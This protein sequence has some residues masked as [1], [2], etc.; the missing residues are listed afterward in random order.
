MHNLTEAAGLHII[1]R[2]GANTKGECGVDSC[3]SFAQCLKRTLA[4]EDMSA[5]EAARLVG[6]KSR[7][8][9]FRILQ[10]STSCDINEHFLADLRAALGETWPES[11]YRALEEAL[12]ADRLG[13]DR[14]RC[15]I[16]FGKMLKGVAEEHA[17]ITVQT[18]TLEGEVSEMTLAEL[19]TQVAKCPKAEIVLTS[20]CDASFLRQLED[21]CGAAGENGT[22]TIRHYVDT[23]EDVVVGNILGILPLLSKTWY[24]ARL[25]GKGSCPAPMMQLYRLHAM[26]INCWD[27]QG[28]VVGYHMTRIDDRTFIRRI[29]ESGCYMINTLDRWRFHLELLKPPQNLTG[30]PQDFVAYTRNYA[31]L[32]EKCT[33]LSIKPD[34]HFNCIPPRILY[35]SIKDG[36]A[37]AGMAEGEELSQLMEE[38]WQIHEMRF[39]NLMRKR[40]PTHLVY[41]LPAMERFMRTGVLTDHFFIQRAYTVAER[42]EIMLQLRKAMQERPWFNVHFLKCGFEPKNEISYYSDRGV[43]IMDACTSYALGDDHSEALITLPAFSWAFHD[44]FTNALLKDAVISRNEALAA[45]DMLITMEI[46]E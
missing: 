15:K 4:A 6:F 30:S 46:T 1:R 42:R 24:N 2:I 18:V 26:Y 7:T 27:E 16:A 36:F 17:P 25:V 28:H 45:L 39:N 41:S 20:C 21:V 43:M 23:T 33:I 22:L 8:S 44:Y 38:L 14:Y 40:K 12:E 10:G 9:I 34:I 32:E 29:W 31:K 5:S 3:E 35:E 11:R 37:V 19:L 13:A